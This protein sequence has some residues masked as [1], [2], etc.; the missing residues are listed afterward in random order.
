MWGVRVVV[1]QKFQ[2]H[3]L[4]ELHQ[5]HLGVV[6]M[7]SLARS[8][9]WW[10]GIDRDIEHVAKLCTG[11]QEV[12]KAPSLAPLHP[13][14]WPATAW[15]RVHVDFAGPFLNYMFIIIVD[16]HSKWPEIFKMRSNTSRDTVGILC[17]V[18]GSTG[19]RS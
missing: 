12:Q 19:V 3:V 15:E 11:C 6:K 14:E 1:P 18:L 2:S 5:G 8:Y 13:W 16:A 9:V 4:Q 10:P 7:K 17:T